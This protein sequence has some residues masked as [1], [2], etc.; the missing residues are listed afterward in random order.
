MR[1]ALG[2]G[3]ASVVAALALAA[4]ANGADALPVSVTAEPTQVSARLGDAFTF[5]TTITNAA[6]S[7]TVPLIAHLNL[8]SLHNDVYVDPEDWSPQR[9]RYLGTIPAGE[10]RTL[11]WALEAVNGGS[12]VAYV[13]VVEEES[14]TLEPATSPPVQ[15]DIVSRDTLSSDGILLLALGVPLALGAVAGGIR[16]KRKR[17]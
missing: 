5:E 3:F 10:S 1:R 12:L 13:T 14:P 7:E 17:R 2:A 16:I 4:A 8:L 9:T 11:T 6:E 15:I